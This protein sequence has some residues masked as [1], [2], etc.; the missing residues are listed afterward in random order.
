MSKTQKPK[1]LKKSKTHQKIIKNHL[2][3]IQIVQKNSY[4]PFL[5]GFTGI[6]GRDAFFDAVFR[7][8]GDEFRDFVHHGGVSGAHQVEKLNC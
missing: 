7:V 8:V 4:Y 1:F 3:K 5:I 6:R 2:Q